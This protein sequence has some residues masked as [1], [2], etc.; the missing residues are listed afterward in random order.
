MNKLLLV[1]VFFAF[2]G[3]DTS[4]NIKPLGED[5]FIKYYGSIGDQ[6]GVSVKAASD[7]GF[8]IGGN[9]VTEFGGQSDYLLIKVDAFGNQEWAR[10][11]NYNIT[12][13]DDFITDVLVEGNNYIIAG[14]SF[15][16]GISKMVL[17]QIDQDGDLIGQLTIDPLKGLEPLD[18]IS[19]FVCNGISKTSVGE[20]LVVGP[21]TNNNTSQ[22]GKSLMSIVS[23]DL[24]TQVNN[25]Y[26][27]VANQFNGELI[28]VKGLEV[29]N[30]FDLE[31]NYLIVASV[32]NGTD[33]DIGILQLNDQF[34][35]I[36][37]QERENLDNT[38]PVDFVKISDSDYRILSAS[39][40]QSY[41]LNIFTEGGGNFIFGSGQPIHSDNFFKGVSMNYTL[42]EQFIVSSNITEENTTTTFSSL[43]ETTA[44]G[45]INWERIFS[46]DFSYK[47]GEVISLNDGSI[48]YTGTAGLK[49][50]T[51]VFLIKLKSNGEMK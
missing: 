21:I 20:F 39:D 24:M 28:F 51:K 30:Q 40:D 34:G 48:V 46:S 41:M 43:V 23:G 29:V 27:K 2:L 49:D 32:N 13:E 18:S 37:S 35:S 26:P 14:T 17:L 25:L 6:E 50:Q 38:K 8:I 10:T 1:L 22:K 3:C 33:T 42:N 36:N 15:I 44:S 31:K 7:G 4:N 5:Y 16:N 19:R 47:S 9:S 45:I 11:Y 12:L